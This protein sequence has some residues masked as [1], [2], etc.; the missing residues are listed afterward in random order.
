VKGGKNIY[1]G[2]WIRYGG[3]DSLKSPKGKKKKFAEKQCPVPNRKRKEGGKGKNRQG[4]KVGL[5]HASI[6]ACGQQIVLQVH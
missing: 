4:Q 2:M 5:I 1:E 6:F 3:P